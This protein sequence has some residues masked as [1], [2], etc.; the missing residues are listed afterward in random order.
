MEDFLIEILESFGYPVYRQGSLTK[1]EYPD[2][3]F[4]FWNSDTPDHSHYDNQTYGYEWSFMVNF[5]SI[6]PAL[7]YSSLESARLLLKQ[8]GWT[9]PGKGYDVASDEPTHTGRGMTAL[10]L[11]TDKDFSFIQDGGGRFLIAQ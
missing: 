5:Y 11:E 8:N 4:T 1:K 10:Y 2:H 6:D 9:I 7:T 3:F